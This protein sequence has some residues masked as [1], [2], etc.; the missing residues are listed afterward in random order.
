MSIFTMIHAVQ[1]IDAGSF[2]QQYQDIIRSYLSKQATKSH[3]ISDESEKY[4]TAQM[5]IDL[6]NLEHI[7]SLLLTFLLTL[8]RW[9]I[10]KQIPFQII[11][12]P[13]NLKGLANVYGIA[14]LVNIDAT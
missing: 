12:I 10:S 3:A 9:S 7:N 5:T 13:F 1:R 11:H 6:Q 14:E 8:K 4:A 2:D